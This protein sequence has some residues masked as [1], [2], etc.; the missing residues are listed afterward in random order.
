VQIEF[1]VLGEAGAE[2][3]QGADRGAHWMASFESAYALWKMGWS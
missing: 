1:V 2:P 3:Q